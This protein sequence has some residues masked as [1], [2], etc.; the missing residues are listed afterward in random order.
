MAGAGHQL[1]RSHGRCSAGRDSD[2]SDVMYC[3]C[4]RGAAGVEVLMT[5]LH[6]SRQLQ[7]RC[8]GLQCAAGRSVPGPQ[9]R[10]GRC[11]GSSHHDPHPAA[12]PL[13][14]RHRLPRVLGQPL[15]RPPPRH[16]LRVSVH[17][18]YNRQI[19]GGESSHQLS[20]APGP[21]VPMVSVSGA[22]ALVT[23]HTR[24][25]RLAGPGLINNGARPGHKGHHGH[26]NTETRNK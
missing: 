11:A 12:A 20:P 19:L 4:R 17:S 21:G 13:H 24:H 2:N 1:L 5:N 15:D 25:S 14:R 22:F 18:S 16:H 9:S 26:S 23:L 7:P 10:P 6:C 8:R 3:D